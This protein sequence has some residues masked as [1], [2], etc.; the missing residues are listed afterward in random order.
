MIVNNQGTRWCT[1]TLINNV[2]EDNTRYFLTA[3][4]CLTQAPDDPS[5]WMFIF[6]Y[7]SPVCDPSEN[8]LL[9]NSVFGAEIIASSGI[10]DFA[11]LKL[12]QDLPV[13]YGIYYS[14]WYRPVD[15]I[16]ETVSIH[17][18]SGDVMK[19]SKD[20]EPPELS[21]YFGGAGE[22]YW[23][24]TDWDL[25]TT[26]GGSSGSALFNQY[27]Q[28][29]GQLRGGQAACGNSLP[30][31]YGAFYKSWD[32]DSP[33][34][35]LKDWLDPENQDPD[36]ISGHDPLTDAVAEM[37]VKTEVRIYPNPASKRVFIEIPAGIDAAQITLSDAA[38]RTFREIKI[39]RD[40]NALKHELSLAGL[41][42]GLYFVQVHGR[43]LIMTF[44]LV[45]N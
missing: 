23:K 43:N 14:G 38:G 16:D 7:K 5:T 6:N 32:G 25:G 37:S 13:A 20:F 19:I 9:G 17:H 3:T 27:G 11:L 33:E 40:A 8:G 1:G 39:R 18:P 12:N 31:Y 4:H 22:D 35:R 34:K 45:V 41:S 29:I 42:R 28:I 15:G 21:G 26:E 10:S 36:S 24:V 2:K 44:R 30:D